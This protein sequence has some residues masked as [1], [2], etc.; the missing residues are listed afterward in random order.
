MKYCTEIFTLNC[1]AYWLTQLLN[2]LFEGTI[3]VQ[4]ICLKLFICVYVIY[5]Y[6]TVD[7]FA[8]G[9]ALYTSY[10]FHLIFFFYVFFFNVINGLGII[11]LWIENVL[12]HCL[13][14]KFAIC[15]LYNYDVFVFSHSMIIHV[16]LILSQFYIQWKCSR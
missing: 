9:F 7:I 13:Y 10:V 8:W 1:T 11:F 16:F 14:Y 2:M 5:Y 15:L 6:V 3:R 4:W 12:F